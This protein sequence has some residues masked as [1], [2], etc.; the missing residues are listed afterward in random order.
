MRCV[1]NNHDLLTWPKAMAEKLA[2]QGHEVIFADNGSTWQPLL[3]WYESCPFQ[4]VKMDNLG[5]HGAWIGA[6]QLMADQDFYVVT[7]PDL[8]ISGMPDD[9]PEI[10]IDEVKRTKVKAGPHLYD[11]KIPTRNHTWDLGAYLYPDGNNPACWAK[12]LLMH[13]PGKVDFWNFPIDTTFAVYPKGAKYKDIAG[14]RADVPYCARHLPWHV[15]VEPNPN[16]T[17]SIQIP[18]DEEIYNYFRN[19]LSCSGT[20]LLMRVQLAEYEDLHGRPWHG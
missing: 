5:Q 1:I 6:P 12:G 13:R 4:V 15:V 2:S 20:S 8:D 18:M 10:F 7:D 17:R 14:T 11:D 16:E 3:D 19:A 9:W